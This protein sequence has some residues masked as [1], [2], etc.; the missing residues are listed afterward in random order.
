MLLRNPG[1]HG[2]H[3]AIGVPG[4]PASVAEVVELQRHVEFLGAQ[5]GNGFLQIV[6]FL[7]GYPYLLTLD[8][9]LYFQLAILDGGNDL[10]ARSLSMPSRNLASCFISLPEA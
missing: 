1:P 7:A 10:F 3:L 5:Q 2:H 4:H 6:T 8:G 9:G